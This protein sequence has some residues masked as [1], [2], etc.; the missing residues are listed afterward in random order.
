MADDRDN[1]VLPRRVLTPNSS[2]ILSHR[3]E[4]P[5]NIQRGEIQRENSILQACSKLFDK[6]DI[7]THLSDLHWHSGQITKKN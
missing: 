2:H 6:D 3:E 4:S 1:T 7:L 5:G